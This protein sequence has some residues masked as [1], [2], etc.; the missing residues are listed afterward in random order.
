MLHHRALRRFPRA[1]LP[2]VRPGLRALDYETRRA[3]DDA[4]RYAPV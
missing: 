2:H 4:H 1:L 3:L